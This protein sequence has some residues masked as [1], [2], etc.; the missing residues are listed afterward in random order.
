MNLKK[1][2]TVLS[3]V[4]IAVLVVLLLAICWMFSNYQDFRQSYDMRFQSLLVAK[5]L[6]QTSNDLTRYC[7]TY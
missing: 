7:R 1:L 6:Q 4:S 2:F 5:E 3:G